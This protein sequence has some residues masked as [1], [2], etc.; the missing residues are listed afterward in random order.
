MLSASAASTASVSAV[1]A[2]VVSE[3]APYTSATF[4]RHFSYCAALCF[5][6]GN[7]RRRHD[8]KAA[9]PSGSLRSRSRARISL[10]M[11]AARAPIRHGENVR[12]LK[13]QAQS[14]THLQSS[15]CER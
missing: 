7:A 15:V 11:A 14:L 2:A 13:G 10:R 8:Q 4:A 6:S 5:A 3:P 12:V 1:A 9:E